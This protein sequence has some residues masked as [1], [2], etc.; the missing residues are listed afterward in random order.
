ME[1]EGDGH[2]KV[3]DKVKDGDIVDDGDVENN[4]DGGKGGADDGARSG[5][6]KTLMWIWLGQREGRV[7]T[8]RRRVTS[9]Q[10]HDMLHD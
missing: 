7:A 5:K 2:W 3:E 6:D 1:D 10:V 8:S 4:S 9:G